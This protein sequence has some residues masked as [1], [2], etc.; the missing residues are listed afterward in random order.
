L[1][2]NPLPRPVKPGH[3]DRWERAALF[4]ILAAVALLTGKVAFGRVVDFTMANSPAMTPLSA[5]RTNGVIS[6][7]LPI[8][9]LLFMRYQRRQGRHPGPLAWSALVGACLFSLTAQL[10]QAVPTVGG[11]IVAAVPSVAFMVLSKMVVSMRPAPQP[12]ASCTTGDAAPARAV[13]VPAS[14]EEPVLPDTSGPQLEQKSDPVPD[15]EQ[16]V[17]ALPTA[18]QP[19]QVRPKPMRPRSLSKALEV[20]KAARELGPEAMPAAVAARAGVS[21]STARRYMPKESG[22]N[23]ATSA[24]VADHLMAVSA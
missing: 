21:E 20:E 3:A 14:T 5:G 24:R 7:I 9:V 19:E 18:K 17:P 16:A 12:I 13:R 10:A 1:I 22:K 11:W 6:E 15:V 2:A 8:G 4:L 23:S